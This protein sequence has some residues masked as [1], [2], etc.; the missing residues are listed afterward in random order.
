[1]AVERLSTTTDR[2]RRHRRVSIKKKNAPRRKKA[3]ANVLDL[4]VVEPDQNPKRERD[5]ERGRGRVQDP[6]AISRPAP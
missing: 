5:L 1:M 6:P 4:A 3:T 2:H